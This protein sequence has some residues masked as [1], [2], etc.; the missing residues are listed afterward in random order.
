MEKV[1]KAFNKLKKKFKEKPIF[2]TSD[3]TKPFEIFADISNH[4]TGAVLTQRDAN[5]VQHSCFF[6]SK[7]LLLVEKHYHTSE[8]EFLAII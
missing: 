3:P 7:P 5:R 4:T 1:Q 6:Y 2:I 8:Q